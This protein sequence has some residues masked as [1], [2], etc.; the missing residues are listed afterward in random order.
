MWRGWASVIVCRSTPDDLGTVFQLGP[1]GRLIRE[2]HRFAQAGLM[3]LDDSTAETIEDFLT[4]LFLFVEFHDLRERVRCFAEQ[5]VDQFPF[6]LLG[7]GQFAQHF[8][9]E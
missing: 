3:H 4:H 6:H 8:G 1:E 5:P 9:H 7:V 2:S